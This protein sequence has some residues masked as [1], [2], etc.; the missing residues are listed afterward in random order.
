MRV[1]SCG[2]PQAELAILDGILLRV[3][4][5]PLVMNPRFLSC[6]ACLQASLTLGW[7]L[8][9]RIN[10]FVADNKNGLS[11]QDGAETDWVEIYNPNPVAVD[12]TGWYLTDDLGA[13][14]KWQFPG[15]SI[16]GN[17]YLVVFASGKNRAVA[18]NE[19]HTNFSLRANGE[20]LA[21]VKPDGQTIASQFTFGP[22]PQDVSYGNASITASDETLIAENASARALVPTNNALGTT[23]TGTSFN[24]ATWASGPLAV[25]YENSSG[26]QSL[27][28]LD[29]RTAMN[30]V[31]T[32]CYIRVPF[33][34]A[35]IEDALALTLRMRYDD[36]FAVYLNGTLLSTAGRNAPSTL[37]DTSA[38]T[39]DHDDSVAMLYEDI[40][41]SQHLGL[42]NPSGNNV[43]AIHGLNSGL[44]SSDFLIGPQLVLTRGTYA[45]G[46][47]NNP[48]PGAANTNGV[49]GYVSDTQFS[50]DRGFYNAPIN[51]AI[52]C[53]TPGAIIR[54]T[55][56]GDAPTATTGTVYAG[57]IPISSTTTL[58]AGAFKAGFQPSNV[59]THTYFYLDDILTQSASGA[60][61][62]GWPTG[63]VNSQRFDYGMDPNVV[64]GNAP[65]VRSALEAIPTVSIVT[66]LPNLVD[67]TTGIYANPGNHGSEWER[68]AS[69]EILNDPVN[70]S[71]NGFQV[72][73]G[74]R[75][76][77][78]FSRD[79]N[80]PKHSFRLLF[81]SEYGAK[82]L[83]YKMFGDEGAPDFDTIDLRTSQDAS[84]AYLGSTANTF[85]RDEV[86]RMSQVA[87]SPGSRCRYLHVYLN[88]QY[89]GLYN[90]DERPDSSY[91]EQ[92]LGGVKE[93]YDVV[94][95]SGASGGYAT[96][97]SEG[98]MATG[99]A[100]HQLWSGARAVR[101]NPTN[102]NYFKLMGRAADGVTPTSDPVVLDATNLADYLITLFYMGGNDG[103][104]SDY[105]GA[106]N[107][108]FGMRRRT[109][110]RGFV[111]FIHDFEQSL[112][113]EGGNNQRVGNGSQIRP[114]SNT[115]SGVNDINRSNPEF[116]HE[117]LAWNAEY[118]MHFADRVH[119]HL[120]NGGALT[121]A[122]V[123]GRMASMGTI[124]DSCIWAESARWGDSVT[125]PPLGRSDYLT[126]KT[127]L[128]NFIIWGTTNTGTGTGRVNEV[129]RQFRG[130]DAAAKPLYPT[131]IA[132]VFSQ[133]G[134][135]I[136]AAG[137]SITMTEANTGTRTLYYTVNGTDP[138]AVG[139]AVQAGALTY[140]GPV[141]LNAWT[142]NVKA[143]VLKAGVWSAL[144]EAVF[145]RNSGPP[146][147]RITEI[148]SSPTSPT[149]AEIAAGYD[150]KDDFEWIELMNTGTESLNLREM[151]F[152]Q[153]ID[154]IF[155]FNATLAPGERAV[156]VRNRAA[157]VFRYGTTPRVLGEFIGAL[158]DGGERLAILSALGVATRD[159]SYDAAAPWP[160]FNSGGS[161]VLR[162]ADLN[163]ALPENWRPSLSPQGTPGSSDAVNY[164]AWQTANGVTNE[165]TDTDADGLL[166]L[167]EYASGG[168]ATASDAH[169]VPTLQLAGELVQ[170]SF[171]WK[172]GADDLIAV[173]E[174]SADLIQWIP[175]V[176]ALTNVTSHPDGTDVMTYQLTAT[177][178]VFLRVRWTTVP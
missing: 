20:A 98:S 79:G 87:I 141:A 165:T 171:P 10:E 150:D 159:F 124:V 135:G 169:R 112:G 29:V 47:M 32:S 78:G 137:T 30:N 81:R 40:S 22:Q 37:N 170:I 106:S 66:N 17:G 103:P 41:I 167:V 152:H 2:D 163:P 119:R 72:N 168:T 131:T 97:A 45:V 164:A 142:T 75:I 36:G 177:P 57:P 16:N 70:P 102:A 77:G 24:D 158:N 48:T 136:P 53:A 31:R 108:W 132:P 12:L 58:R 149:A 91:G 176:A 92:Y 104:V 11:D 67:A 44:G 64:N 133:H 129:I 113:L 74:V 145:S 25:G 68:P 28:G 156:L 116:I 166:P 157:F 83:N 86:A 1:A 19:L 93:D 7:A 6:W 95:S 15:T 148:M 120:T 151:K 143:R 100:W 71:P 140:S 80:N 173:I 162:R 3:S 125:E 26:Y 155:D 114:W 34:V 128:E 9:P 52:T 62:A 161:L 49:E 118:R 59:D 21:L 134:G 35:T 43:L 39:G 99:S 94:K 54:Y 153:G 96:E 123:L 115:V 76:R 178:K 122:K 84:W 69:V 46:F 88:G 60:A 110:S 101:A 13:L 27:I 121:D 144:N 55:L 130:Y 85:L 175:A 51:V 65:A 126:A 174:Q 139:G 172:R 107:N 23:W 42:L 8:D 138:R 127:N 56:N 105:V 111:Y 90:T 18:G 89:W 14:T 160:Q 38:A 4:T 154:F 147:L 50:V 82:K 63:Y 5:F 117:D 109:G 146:P 61:P 33:T 73:A